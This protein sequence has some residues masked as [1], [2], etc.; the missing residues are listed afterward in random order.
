MHTTAIIFID[1]RV[2][3]MYVM[4]Q[5]MHIGTNPYAPQSYDQDEVQCKVE[6]KH[7]DYYYGYRWEGV[8]NM[9]NKL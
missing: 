3:T 2:C 6:G 5:N 7:E 1:A 9:K 4:P 8:N